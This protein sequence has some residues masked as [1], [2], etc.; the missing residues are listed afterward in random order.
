MT[1][2]VT[3]CHDKMFCTLDSWPNFLFLMVISVVMMSDSLQI[4]N[5]RDNKRDI[6]DEIGILQNTS[7]PNDF[8]L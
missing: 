3:N 7:E 1:V 6:S 8:L 2:K 5:N 4:P